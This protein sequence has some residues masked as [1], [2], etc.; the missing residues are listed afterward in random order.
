MEEKGA[1]TRSGVSINR[2]FTNICIHARYSLET[3]TVD[4]NTVGENENEN[5]VPYNVNGSGKAFSQKALLHAMVDLAIAAPNGM[6][7]AQDI[8]H[9]LV[10]LFA[11]FYIL[12]NFSFLTCFELR[13]SIHPE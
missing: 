2:M 10:G 6:I 8:L 3:N 1:I 4:M 11:G 5:E 9:G 12:Y 13:V 7:L